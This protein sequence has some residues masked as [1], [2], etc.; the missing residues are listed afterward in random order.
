VVK[1]GF[2]LRLRCNIYMYPASWEVGILSFTG[3]Q[4]RG[5]FQ[6]ADINRMIVN[7]IMRD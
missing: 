3:T 4:S 2:E 6:F 1:M 7:V 5:V